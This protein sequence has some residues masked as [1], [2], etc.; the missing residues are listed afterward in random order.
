VIKTTGSL[1]PVLGEAKMTYQWDR[2]AFAAHEGITTRRAETTEKWFVQML[3]AEPLRSYIDHY[4]AVSVNA[5]LPLSELML[6]TTARF[7]FV[8]AGSWSLG[9]HQASGA[10]FRGSNSKAQLLQ[11]LGSK[12]L[13]VAL[14]PLGF[15]TLCNR[16][17]EDFSDVI[18]SAK[19][20]LE[21]NFDPLLHALRRTV[22]EEEQ[23]ICA[24][25]FFGKLIRRGRATPDPMLGMLERWIT[26]PDAM[27]VELMCERLGMSHSKLGRLCRRFFGFTPKFLLRRARF[28][29]MLEQ[30]NLRPYQEWR[31]FLDARYVDQSH[32][33]RDFHAFMGMTPSRYLAQARPLMVAHVHA[34]HELQR[35]MRHRLAA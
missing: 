27:T 16:S 15:Q 24:D 3:P 6:C 21:Y 22:T 29:R 17:A 20:V 10:I 9:R 19:G 35:F 33:I 7:D 13:S 31:T 1:Q 4:T 8:S 23:A 12:T 30:L 2:A 25:D 14:T 18:V 34:R 5:E 26:D 28:T 32:F 11:S